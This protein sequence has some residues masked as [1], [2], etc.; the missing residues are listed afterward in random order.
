MSFATPAFSATGFPPSTPS[1]RPGASRAGP[2]SS[3]FSTAFPS[4]GLSAGAG[5]GWGTLSTPGGASHHGAPGV[6]RGERAN[7]TLPSYL[8]PAAAASNS[9]P[10]SR[11]VSASAARP[12]LGGLPSAFASPGV[13]SPRSVQSYASYGRYADSGLRRRG[14]AATSGGGGASSPRAASGGDVPPV[15]SVY[16]ASTLGTP[17]VDTAASYT[18]ADDAWS[19]RGTGT[20]PRHS[21]LDAVSPSAFSTMPA[22][23]RTPVRASVLSTPIGVSM[24]PGRGVGPGVG[25]DASD[26]S[27]VTVFGFA[28]DTASLVLRHFQGLGDV[29]EWRSGPGNWMHIRYASPVLAAKALSRNGKN[30]G[31]SLMVGVV[32]CADPS[33]AHGAPVGSSSSAAVASP[34]PPSSVSTRRHR[35]F[36]AAQREYAVDRSKVYKQPRAQSSSTCTRLLRYVFGL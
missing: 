5:S 28:P 12:P 6:V 21:A 1:S 20:P 35:S 32:P 4:A 10:V 25:G 7:S 11:S 2:G 24:T 15:A 19:V 29:L 34:A 23:G 26:V 17:H 13:S 36:R 30:L 16:E 18:D 27:W 22:D 33:V 8:L 3:D 14:G 9:S 31:G